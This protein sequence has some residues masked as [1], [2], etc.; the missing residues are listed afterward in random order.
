[1]VPSTPAI[2]PPSTTP[3]ELVLYRAADESQTLAFVNFYDPSG[4]GYAT[5]SGNRRWGDTMAVRGAGAGTQ[6]LLGT[7]SGNAAAI[8]TPTDASMTDFTCTPLA[9]DVQNGAIGYG[10]AFGAGNTFW[11]KG[12]STAGNPLLRLS[13]DLGAGTATTLQTYATTNF[14]GRVGPL[15]LNVASNLL[16]AIEPLPNVVDRVR[17]Y[18]ASN[19]ANP[20]VLLDWWNY[21]TNAAENN[22]YAGAA[23]FGTNSSGVPTLYALDCNSGIMAFS[24]VPDEPH[25]A[26][27]HLPAAVDPVRLSRHKRDSCRGRRWRSRSRRHYQWYFN[28]TNLI[29]DANSY[30]AHPRQR[31]NQRQRKLQRGCSRILSARSPVRWRG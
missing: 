14:P 3:P 31:P 22:V 11:A 5:N 13:F 7:Q 10:V 20:P 8:L 28:A 27:D 12:A 16:A 2:C 4:G 30:V 9:T 6:I 18:D 29:A 23:A 26:P 1:M 24:L 19:L 17:L 21:P 25:L 15:M